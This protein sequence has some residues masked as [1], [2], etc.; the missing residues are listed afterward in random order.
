MNKDE[1]SKCST[2]KEEN[3]DSKKEVKKSGCCKPK[4]TCNDK[5]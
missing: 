2:P 1:K 4:T 5:K 3:C